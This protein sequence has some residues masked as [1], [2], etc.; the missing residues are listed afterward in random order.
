MAT[1]Y[2]C[3]HRELVLRNRARARGDYANG[4]A[5]T[6]GPCYNPVLPSEARAS[7]RSFMSDRLCPPRR[8]VLRPLTVVRHTL[9]LAP[10]LLVH[11][12]ALAVF[13]VEVNSTAWVALLVMVYFRGFLTTAGLH[14]Y[15][16]HRSFKTSRGVQ[17][18]LAVL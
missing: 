5:V 6:S 14:R 3:T 16:S 8:A 17:F 10:M 9:N 15:F 12:G 18:V 2:C 11:A 7:P 4:L 13:W 1:L